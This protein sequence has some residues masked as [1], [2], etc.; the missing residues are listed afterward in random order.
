MKNFKQLREATK[1]NINKGIRPDDAE[2]QKL[3]DLPSDETQLDDADENN[4]NPDGSA[5]SMEVKAFKPIYKKRED[6]SYT[7]NVEDYVMDVYKNQTTINEN[8]IDT[9]KKS[10][11]L[12]QDITLHIGSERIK[13]NHEDA[14][15]ILGVHGSLNTNN[16]KKMAAALNSGGAQFRRMLGFAKQQHKLAGRVN[17]ASKLPGI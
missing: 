13:V 8:V 3:D 7:L 6:G 4:R 14:A 11:S 1:G 10:S 12:A 16:Q 9:L 15:A 5:D 17:A 2:E